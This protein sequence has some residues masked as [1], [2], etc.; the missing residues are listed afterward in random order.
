MWVR[1]GHGH[2]PSP[3]PQTLLEDERN[4]VW[5][6][7]ISLAE[8]V[9]L[10]HR[11][12]LSAQVEAAIRRM[13]GLSHVLIPSE[14]T[15]EA[16][17]RLHAAERSFHRDFSLADALILAQAQEMGARLLTTDHALAR[18]RQGVRVKVL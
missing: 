8:L 15:F 16:A 10:L 17:G 18:N 1:L 6:S 7:A 2:P 12:G 14:E 9:S 5:T 13:K 4:E 3:E 11:R